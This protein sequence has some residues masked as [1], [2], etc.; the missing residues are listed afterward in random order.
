[1]LFIYI[2]F[3][4]DKLSC[5][6]FTPFKVIPVTC[7]QH[8]LLNRCSYFLILLQFDDDKSSTLL[9]WLPRKLAPQVRV[10][11]SMIDNTPPHKLLK[12]RAIPPKE[13]FVTPLDMEARKVR[14]KS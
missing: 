10:V 11:L 12:E 9:S 13:I 3:V 6:F 5:V 8:Q 1:M 14:I 4:F 7:A 2:N